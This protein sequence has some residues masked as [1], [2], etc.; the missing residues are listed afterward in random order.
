[1]IEIEAKNITEGFWILK[2]MEHEVC[3][4]EFLFDATDLEIL[5]VHMNVNNRAGIVFL[6]FDAAYERW[7]Q[8]MHPELEYQIY[9]GSFICGSVRSSHMTEAGRRLAEA[10]VE[11]KKRQ[12]AQEVA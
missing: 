7:G 1:M 4:G 11:R 5:D 6:L 9:N 12:L 8:F 3:L 10:W 2:A